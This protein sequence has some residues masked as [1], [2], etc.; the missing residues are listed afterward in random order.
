MARGASLYID[1]ED[2]CMGGEVATHGSSPVT[3]GDGDDKWRKSPLQPTSVHLLEE[4]L[5]KRH[6]SSF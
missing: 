4:F 6:V 1:N 5:R 2:Q 3:N